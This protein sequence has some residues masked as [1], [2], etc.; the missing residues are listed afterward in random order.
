MHHPERKAMVI[1][2]TGLVGGLLVHSLLGHPAYSEVRI[3]VR[4]T[5]DLD[6]PRLKQHVVDWEQLES[7]GH[8]F[9]GIDDLYCCLGTTIK[10]RAVRIDF[11]KW[12]IIIR[13]AQ[14]RWQ[15]NMV[16]SRC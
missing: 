3:L 13:F 4:R 1:G 15:S 5:L 7:Q 10:K 16:W 8:L 14:P 6:N 11:V 2:A 12:I 9:E